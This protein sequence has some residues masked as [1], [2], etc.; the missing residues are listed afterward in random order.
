MYFTI[1]CCAGIRA[2]VQRALES[3]WD[4]VLIEDDCLRESMPEDRCCLLLRLIAAKHYSKVME[5]EVEVELKPLVGQQE[6][7]AAEVLRWN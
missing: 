6:V 3:H 1:Q 5:A 2:P 4:V 7:V